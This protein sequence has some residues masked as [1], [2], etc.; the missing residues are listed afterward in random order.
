[1]LTE[2]MTCTTA[3]GVVLDGA[4]YDAPR[5]VPS[6]TQVLVVHGLGW[7]FYQ[8]PSRWLPPR[9]AAMGYTTLAINLRDH[10]LKDPKD[11]DL[12]Y[13]DLCAGVD[14]LY[15]HGAGT[16]VVLGH[17]YACNKIVRYPAL[18]GDRRI[19]HWVFTTMGSVKR[20]RPEIWFAGLDLAAQLAGHILV[21]QGAVDASLEGSARVDELAAAVRDARVD[22]VSLE[23]GDHYFT[24][25][26][27]ELAGCVGSW[28]ARVVP[29]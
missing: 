11:F 3:D 2:L 7:N 20:V 4:L 25:R 26:H 18:S 12:A 21:V 17:G 5:P 6:A 10:D 19:R 23:G 22:A 9:L 13:H 29:E 24:D 8:G 16:V 1:M 14:F 27:A 28:L 15:G